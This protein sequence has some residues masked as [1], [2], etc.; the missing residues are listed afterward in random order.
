M[1]LTMF[2]R[3]VSTLHCQHTFQMAGKNVTITPNI[4]ELSL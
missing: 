3:D 2:M 1:K 4:F